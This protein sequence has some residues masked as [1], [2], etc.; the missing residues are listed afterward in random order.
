LGWHASLPTDNIV[1]NSGETQTGPWTYLNDDVAV[2]IM[3]TPLPA[4]LLLLGSGLIVLA[5][6]K[7]KVRA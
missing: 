7:E 3:V 4:T 1:A 6:F 5:A 2:E